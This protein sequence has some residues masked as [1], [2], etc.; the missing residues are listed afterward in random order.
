LAK[1]FLA[2]PPKLLRHSGRSKTG[3]QKSDFAGLN[4]LQTIYIASTAIT[5]SASV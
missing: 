2:D 1:G 4:Q 3:L 5:R